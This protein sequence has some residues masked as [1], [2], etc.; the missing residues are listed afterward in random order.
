MRLAGSCILPR[1]D[2][3]CV[4]ERPQISNARAQSE[5]VQNVFIVVH[6]SRNEAVDSIIIQ[7]EFTFNWQCFSIT[8]LSVELLRWG[9]FELIYDSRTERHPLKTIV[10]IFIH[11]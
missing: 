10:L 6:T 1:R 7:V 3:S 8:P 2:S 9:L 11:P 5:R 4:T